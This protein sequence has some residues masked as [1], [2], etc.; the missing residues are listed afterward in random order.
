MK[1]LN[2]YP[3]VLTV[4]QVCAILQVSTKTVYKLIQDKELCAK[5]IASQYRI[6]KKELVNFIGED[7]Q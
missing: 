2:N 7:N 1:M 3:D 4:K 5:K 6:P